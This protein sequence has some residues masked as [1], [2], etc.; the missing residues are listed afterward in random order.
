MPPLTAL[1]TDS[2]LV[3]FIMPHRYRVVF[4]DPTTFTLFSLRLRRG[5]GLVDYLGIYTY[6]VG[7]VIIVISRI[8]APLKAALISAW[9]LD[10]PVTQGN[11]LNDLG[12]HSYASL[13]L[14]DHLYHNPVLV[15]CVDLLAR[16]MDAARLRRQQ[17]LEEHRD[18]KK[19][20]AA[21][22]K[23]RG[24]FMKKDAVAGEAADLE[25][26]E[27][28]EQG[29]EQGQG[30]VNDWFA[31]ERLSPDEQEVIDRHRQVGAFVRLL[32]AAEC[33]CK[34]PSHSQPDPQP[35]IQVELQEQHRRAIRFKWHVLLTLARNPKL[36]FWRRRWFPERPTVPPPLATV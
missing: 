1:L 6:L 35:V 23:L 30:N 4:T 14:G 28:Q 3:A 13:L 31:G 10:N 2:P 24:R 7:G 5:W 36:Q 25:A 11:G 18:K 29:Q 21:W 8:I 12:F 17:A 19:S 9:R 26:G 32:C 15:V 22:S 27:A 34:L 16:D 20:G 33:C